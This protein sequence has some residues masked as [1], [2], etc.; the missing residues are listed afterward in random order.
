MA[1]LQAEEME[2]ADVDTVVVVVLDAVKEAWLHDAS[3]LSSRR[4]M[5]EDVVR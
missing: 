3:T 1:G 4:G 5:E 2:V